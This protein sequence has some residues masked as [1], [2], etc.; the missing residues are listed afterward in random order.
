MGEKC[1]TLGREVVFCGRKYR[2]L[3]EKDGILGEKMSYSLERT[4]ILERKRRCCERKVIFL[5]KE[6]GI[7][8]EDMSL[9][10][11]KTHVLGEK[12]A[13]FLEKHLHFA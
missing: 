4:V 2:N 5:G 9:I 10:R 6:G 13:Y 3:V 7:L 11:M 1:P 12:M 8:V